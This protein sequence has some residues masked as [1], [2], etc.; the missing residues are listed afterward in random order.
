MIIETEE[1]TFTSPE[2][3]ATNCIAIVVASLG[4]PA[5]VAALLARLARQTLLPMQV[6]LSI[7]SEADAPPSAE[8]PFDV[9][10]IFGTRGTSIQRNRGLDRLDPRIEIVVF[11]DDDFVPSAFAVERIAGF[12]RRHPHVAGATGKVLVDGIGGPGLTPSEGARIADAY[13]ETAGVPDYSI[14]CRTHGL[15]GCNMAYRVSMIEGIRFDEDL[16]LYA[17]LEDLDFGGRVTA[18]SLVKTAAFAGVHCGEKRGRE[19]SG[20][21]LGY[22]QVV[23]PIYMAR[24]GTLPWRV[25]IASATLLILKNIL[26]LV[27]PEPWIDRRGRTVGNWI[28]IFDLLADRAK[29]D[30]ILSL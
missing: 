26:R 20:R 6:I 25:A 11:Y 8:Y 21:R 18:G 19:K 12:F 13:D 28:A 5:S 9:L 30:R 24:K 17:W 14:T 29:P 22:S 15:Y 16:P 4:R 10:R 3:A 23:N 27:R 2:A 1:R 7:E